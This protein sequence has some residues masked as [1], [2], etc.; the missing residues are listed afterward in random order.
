M[1]S[2]LTSNLEI[3]LYEPSRNHFKGAWNKVQD[4]TEAL[5][6]YSQTNFDPNEAK[7]RTVAKIL[8]AQA[9]GL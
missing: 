9:Q 5:K 6:Q 2:I 1:A 4:V 8:A 3:S 7:D